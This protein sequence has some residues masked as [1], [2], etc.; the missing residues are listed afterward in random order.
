M[1]RYF[2]GVDLPAEH[3]SRIA[4]VMRRLGDPLPVPHITVKD[5]TGL[6][7]DL[8]WLAPVRAAV[9]QSPPFT[10]TIGPPGHFGVRV[11]YLSVSCPDL[12]VVRDMIQRAMQRDHVEASPNTL[13]QEFT[14]H[15]T[16]WVARHGR[17]A[18]PLEEYASSLSGLEP[19]QVDELTVFRRDEARPPYHAWLRLPLK[20]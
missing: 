19:F 13:D 7:P 9:A 10:V 14:P 15:L 12:E 11:L 1:Y 3:R 8:H 6:T 20:G 4:N 2:V 18:P 17:R 5:P 16:L